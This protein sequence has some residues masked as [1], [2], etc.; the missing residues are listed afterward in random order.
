MLTLSQLLFETRVMY[1]TWV[2]WYKEGRIWSTRMLRMILNGG[3]RIRCRAVKIWNLTVDE[4]L[5]YAEL[6]TSFIHSINHN[7]VENISFLRTLTWMMSN[8]CIRIHCRAVYNLR[9][10]SWRTIMFCW[11]GHFGHTL[12][13]VQLRGKYSRSVF[14][15]GLAVQQFGF[16]L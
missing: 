14:Y 5:C 15:F 4:Q 12:F 11:V 9:S 16:L 7:S 6:V 13:R 10:H 1:L 8:G 3:I 2:F